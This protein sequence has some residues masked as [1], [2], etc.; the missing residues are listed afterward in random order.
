[1]R[2]FNHN[3]VNAGYKAH[4]YALTDGGQGV[5]VMTNGGGDIAVAVLR[6][7]ATEYGWKDLQPVEKPVVALSDPTLAQYDG[8]YQLGPTTVKVAHAN[9][10]LLIT[11]P[12]FGSRPRE[13]FPS[14]ETAF[15]NLY[16]WITVVFE[17][18]K[19]GVFDATVYAWDALEAKRIP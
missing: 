11:A 4:M 13:F 7:V 14:G 5:V 8:R 1:M 6:S 12:T 19:A 2:S 10:R 9:G 17:K 3:G 16:D 15:F 18:N